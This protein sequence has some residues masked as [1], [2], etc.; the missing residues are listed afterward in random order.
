MSVSQ[1]SGSSVMTKS[2][3]IARSGLSRLALM[4]AAA[5]VLAACSSDV[6]RLSDYP[7][8]DDNTASVSR[9]EKVARTAPVERVA[10]RSL[11]APRTAAVPSTPTP[12]WSRPGYTPPAR[13]ATASAGTVIVRPGQTLYSIARANGRTVREVAA[14]NGIAY[15]Y[16][17]KV[18]QRIRIPGVGSPVS[19]DPTFSPHRVASL[20]NESVHRPAGATRPAA[21]AAP[22]ATPTRGSG[23][24]GNFTSGARTHRVAPG[25][26]LFAL[27]RR[28]GVNPYRIAAYNGLPRNVQLRVG[29]VV[30]IPAAGG[31]WKGAAPKVASAA[32]KSEPR[33]ET[34]AAAPQ[35]AQKPAVKGGKDT[36]RIGGDSA[37]GSAAGTT[38][39]E[40]TA[41]AMFRWP[42]RGRI[43]STFGQKPN[44]TRNE[45]INIAVPEGTDVRASADGV[46]AYAGNE[47][48]GYG[49]LVLIRHAGGW[50]TAYAH[51]KDL[52]VKRGARVRRGQVIAKAGRTG[53][54][55]TPQLHFE[56]RKGATAVN[57]LDYLNQA[58]AMR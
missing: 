24:E 32:P 34:P 23:S 41:A 14:A 16:T 7:P 51:N 54:V 46:V 31:E 43:I 13:R 10:T 19:P 9:A 30:R 48:K 58:T 49:N 29:Q 36:A 12:S 45:G 53:S 8:I 2:K 26:T 15:P 5:S 57:P 20:G 56:I 22:R 1:V 17:L 11:D 33:R 44:G 38:R 39:Q 52:L 47:L 40:A 21:P 3:I 25:E 6:E 18:G 50:V 42:V 35:P 27:G 28:Y 37:A 4:T 55:S